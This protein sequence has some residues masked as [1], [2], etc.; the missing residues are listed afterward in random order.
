M[1]G[2]VVRPQ[3]CRLAASA[4]L[5]AVLAACG[6]SEPVQMAA[7]GAVA[8]PATPFL[9]GAA[10]ADFTPPPHGAPQSDPADCV[11][12]LDAV[13]TGP[14]AFA[15]EEPYVDLKGSGHYDL[16][17][18]FLD[19]NA[20]GRWDGNLLGGGADTPRF[21]ERLADPVTARALVVSNG[22]RILAVEVVDQE[23]LFN[24]YQQRIRQRVA[25]DGY[26]LD[27]IFIS[28]THDESAP[29]TLGLSGVNSLVSGVN[30]Y[31]AEYLVEK[32]A[33]AIERAYDALQPAHLRFAE[34]REP[35]NLRQC[36]SS[37]PYVDDR[38]MPVLQAVAADGRVIAT[39]VSVSQHA[40]TLGFNPDPEQ[41]KW[42]SA[43]WPHFFRSALETRYGGVAIEMAGSVGSVESPEV[44]PSALAQVPQ[45]YIDEDHPAGCRSLFEA[46]AGENHVPLGY[47]GE[48]QAFGEALA[49]AVA[50]ALDGSAQWSA[51]TELWGA[52][53]DVCIPVSNTLFIAAG[54]AGV[55]AQRPVY[56]PGCLVQVPPLPNGSTAGL[57]LQSQVAA[58][59][60]GDG[61]FIALPGEVFPFTYL[62]GFLGPQDLP[63]PRFP[64]PD[65]PLPHLHTPYRF[66]DGLA[67]DMI[68]YIFPRGNGVG[69]PGENGSLTG[70]ND[71]DRFGCG[72]SD[73][74]EAATSR[75]ADLLAAPL[76]ALLD[77]NAGGLAPE[78]VEQ[79]RYV[80]PDGKLSRDPLGGPQIKCA[81]DTRFQPD[82]PAVAVWLPAQGAFRPSA[83]MSL[84]GRRQ[85]APDRD[86]RGYFDAAGDRHWLDVF[87]DL[88]DAPASVAVPT[89]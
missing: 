55:F 29:D 18:P 30:D 10:V 36:W 40:E 73:D 35:D 67:E 89:R 43:D 7:G 13:F 57:A 46:P 24:V 14:R 39:L 49:G 34:A 33:Q 80:L 77:A 4:V 65:W 52:R 44:F 76:I 26:R 60:I 71:T 47:T 54:V 87:P 68:G 83:W 31:F 45:R 20:N 82:G 15:F 58:F 79:G 51:S 8:P 21:Y 19:C 63:D 88:A 37:Y 50:Q 64:L 23:G 62:R 5:G 78:A 12:A 11:G 2:V 84:S 1:I 61:G 56:S 72:H 48:T 22:S 25:A 86:T 28:A 3:R 69:V 70:A 85:T 16:G 6:S 38:L 81:T 66:F 17:D 74:A 53:A 27:G 75:A 9:V 42:I 59:R 41:R 32:S